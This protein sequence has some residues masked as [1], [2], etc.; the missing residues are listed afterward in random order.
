MKN[1]VRINEKFLT[2]LHEFYTQ[3]MDD[4]LREVE[5]MAQ[6]DDRVRQKLIAARES[7]L[8]KLH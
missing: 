1:R 4:I 6:G 3:D 8:S 2:T 5:D 7:Y